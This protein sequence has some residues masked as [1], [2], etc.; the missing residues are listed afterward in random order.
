MK[1]KTIYTKD[2]ILVVDAERDATVN[3][4]VKS[5]RYSEPVRM[6]QVK[7]SYVN[8]CLPI[9]GHLPIG[10]AKGLEN[11][12]LLVDREDE[13]VEEQAK[14]FSINYQS[15]NREILPN[16]FKLEEGFKAGYKAAQ[17]KGGFTLEDMRKAFEAGHSLEADYSNDEAEFNDFIQSI[18]KHEMEY[19][20][21][22]TPYTN[23]DTKETGLA[24]CCEKKDGRTYLTGRWV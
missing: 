23:T 22:T 21:E 24:F 8:E 11:V 2:Y 4:W 9:L 1:T 10:E 6:G 5:A 15:S 16:S 12:P 13:S 14:Q 19:E 7:N 18:T 3:E 17:S 20:V